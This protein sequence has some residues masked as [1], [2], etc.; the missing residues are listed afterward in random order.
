MCR[1]SSL[2][3]ENPNVMVARSPL[4]LAP[5]MKGTNS[6]LVSRYSKANDTDVRNS[7][8][9]AVMASSMN[10][11]GTLRYHSR[12]NICGQLWSPS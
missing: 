5:L 9:P 11:R 10:D 4:K 7:N 6:R 3:A 1:L 12:S 8:G 2:W